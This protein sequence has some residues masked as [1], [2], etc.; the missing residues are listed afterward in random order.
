M[1]FGHCPA[2]SFLVV[3]VLAMGPL[4]YMVAQANTIANTIKL[5]F[6]IILI[7]KN[8][9]IFRVIRVDQDNFGGCQQSDK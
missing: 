4:A 8:Y 6:F 3:T 2:H 1:F 7:I 9:P 5:S